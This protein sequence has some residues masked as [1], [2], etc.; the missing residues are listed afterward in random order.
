[1]VTEQ[2]HRKPNLN[3]FLC[4]RITQHGDKE[5]V[6]Y[7]NIP[8]FYFLCL[9][10]LPWEISDIDPNI[11]TS[12]DL[13]FA[14]FPSTSFSFPTIDRFPQ[15]GSIHPAFCITKVSLNNINMQSWFSVT[16]K[17][18]KPAPRSFNNYD[19]LGEHADRLSEIKKSILNILQSGK[20]KSLSETSH[21]ELLTHI[22][23]G[24]RHADNLLAHIGVIP[25]QR[26]DENFARTAIRFIDR[27]C[28]DLAWAT[29]ITGVSSLSYLRGYLVGDIQ[30]AQDGAEPRYLNTDYQITLAA[31]HK[32][33]KSAM[34]IFDAF[35]K[36]RYEEDP[37]VVD[38]PDEAHDRP[39]T[40]DDEDFVIVE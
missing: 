21:E 18:S 27:I 11:F 40:R 33:L 6:S 30:N 17:L 13:D 32:I 19:F 2:N 22:A 28:G 36:I 25:N 24:R 1:M 23:D 4:T 38:V 31:C 35:A 20:T 14:F 5:I 26:N 9:V 16:A 3:T 12:S 39:R 7:S 37:E 10:N 15:V 8:L 29:E 34:A